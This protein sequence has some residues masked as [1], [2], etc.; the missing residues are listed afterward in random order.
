MSKVILLASGL[1]FI[2]L[3]SQL[4]AMAALFRQL[5]FLDLCII[6]VKQVPS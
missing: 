2:L 1:K 3:K 4:S 6:P 5:N